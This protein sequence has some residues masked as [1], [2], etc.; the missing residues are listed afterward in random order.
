MS[1]TLLQKASQLHQQGKLSEAETLYH[2]LLEEDP[3]QL[4]VLHALAVLYAQSNQYDDALTTLDKAIAIDEALASLYNSKGNVYLRLGKQDEAIAQY[5]KA[6]YY[7]KQYAA[8]YSNLGNA[9]YNKNQLDQ[10]QKYYE[11]AIHL[12]EDYS[13]AHY[14]LGILFTKL[15]ENDKAI[16]HLKKSIALNPHRPTAYG[17]LAE[18]YLNNHE[19]L[20]AIEN[21]QKRLDYQ[22]EHTESFFSLGQAYLQ[23]NQIEEAIAA[24]KKTLILQPEHPEANHYLGNAE[25]ASSDANKALNY[26]FRQLEIN[27]IMES[28]Y[29][30]G[31]LL[32]HQNRH[33][34][35]LQYLQQAAKIEP[36]Y[37]P[38]HINLAALYL[39]LNQV[40][41][42]IRHYKE[43]LIIKPGDPELTHILSALEKGKTP[44]QAPREYLSHLFNQ[45]ATYYDKHLTEHLQYKA[46]E[47]LF[48]AIET[49]STVESAEWTIL[50]L[51]CG[52]GL[53]GV[54]F[55]PFAKQ[56]IGID[57]SEK[58]I[59]AA[60]QKATYDI[61]KVEEVTTA[62]D[63]F[64]END[65]I[66]AGDVFSYIGKLDQIYQ[67]AYEALKSGGLFAFTV[68]KTYTEPYELQKTIR[69][70]HSKKYLATL[71]KKTQFE[72]LRFDNIVLRKQRNIPVEGYL[73]VLQKPFKTL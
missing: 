13:D 28:Y 1:K 2:Q 64:K 37:L 33:K 46:H 9:Y 43:A 50:D 73:V 15:G 20:L 24:F 8:A 71:A 69:Y 56:L 4:D 48:K 60:E 61:L 54:L 55:K 47:L 34:E 6:I 40:S 29:N 21:Y 44:D 58:M 45:Y 7:N 62:L 41:D 10:A 49:E 36:G 30:I 25:L 14:N 72:T 18:I 70:A 39:K 11:N 5:K 32:M 31:V 22:P 17:Q 16:T 42:A 12:T 38:V 19:Y 3:K 59:A 26:Y 53:C 68:E 51:G 66:V 27:P 23:N 52:T 57:V 67:K 63:T 65:L 35:S